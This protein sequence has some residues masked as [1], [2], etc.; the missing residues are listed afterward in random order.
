MTHFVHR[1]ACSMRRVPLVVVLL[2]LV[3][4]G[5]GGGGDGGPGATPVTPTVDNAPGS[6]TLSTTAPFTLQ[7]GASSTITAAVL[8]KDGRPASAVPTW[9]SSD[10]A[11]AAVSSGVITAVKVGSATITATAGTA[12]ASVVVTV[13][14]GAA[15]ALALRTQPAGA[16]IGLSLGTQP[17]IEVRDASGNVVTTS[18]ATITASIASGGGTLGGTTTVNAVSG[19][20]AFSLSIAGAVGP[21][22]LSFSSPGLTSI[23]STELTMTAPPVPLIVTELSNVTFTLFRGAT[24]PGTV[25]VRLTNGGT[26]LLTGITIDGIV[27][28]AGQPT[29]WLAAR[30]DSAV[31]PTALTLT[32]SVAGLTEGTYRAVVRISAPGAT[33]SPLSISVTLTVVTPTAVSYGTASDKVK[34]IDIGASYAPI[35]S[36]TEP[37]GR[38][39][40]GVPVTYVSRSS[41]VASVDANGRITARAEGDAWIVVSTA[42]STDSLFVIVP[43]TA[44]GPLIRTNV[45]T[46]QHRVNDTVF[47]TVFLDTRGG[48][49]G[50]ASLAVDFDLPGFTLL[51]STP[52][53][54]PTPVVNF[55]TSGVFRISVAAATG[56]T[57]AI[58]VL[59]L[60]L[61]GRTLGIVGWL[62][63]YP[64]DVSG[65]DG[66][67]LTPQSTPT[68]LPIVIR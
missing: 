50:G 19:V 51:S 21:R 32:A 62:R 36:V 46:W 16:A 47:V 7:S 42:A 1:I 39:L 30:V 57:G 2:A 68:R 4:G 37:D 63:L 52:P 55:T 41:S 6:I 20:A 29:G 18:S 13:T 9:T 60:K 34:V 28:E 61:I 10:A 38:P 53:G 43:R 23:A 56:M 49:V 8:T 40:A 48:T 15:V 45:T 5:C 64:V 54:P 33:N 66:R 3:A 67:D 14:P 25:R 11:V 35:T 58:P 26:G 12:T 17:V 65:V 27:H 59:N 31:A 22:V 24:T 44:S